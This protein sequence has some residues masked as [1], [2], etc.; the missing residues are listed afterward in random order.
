MS[1]SVK[2]AKTKAQDQ[3]PKKARGFHNFS[4]RKKLSLSH[5]LIAVLALI[6]A[7][8]GLIGIGRVTDKVETM[9]NGPVALLEDSGNLC[10]ASANLQIAILRVVQNDGMSYADYASSAGAD[11][12][13][14]TESLKNL[15]N[16]LTDPD[17]LAVLAAIQSD[18]DACNAS[19]DSL[20]SYLQ[21]GNKVSA[22][23][24]YDTECDSYLEDIAIQAE[25]LNEM[26]VAQG[27]EAYDYAM[28]LSRFLNILGLCIV[29]FVIISSIIFTIRVTTSIT[30]PVNQVTTAAKRFREGDLLA[31]KDITYRSEEELGELAYAVDRTMYTVDTYIKEIIQILEEIG[32]GNLTRSDREITDYVGDFATIKASFTRILGQLNGIMED[33]RT[34]AVQ[35]SDGS[36]QIAAGAQ[37]LAQGAAEQAGSIQE[38]TS[39]LYD[40]V[41]DVNATAETASIAAKFSGL[42]NQEVV[43]CNEQMNQM[44]ATMDDISRHSD[45]ISRI[46]KTIEDIAFQ[47]NILALNAAVEAARAGAAGKGFA[48]VADEVRS[49]ASKSAEASQSTAELIGGTLAAVERGNKIAKE[50]SE[51]LARVVKGTSDIGGDIRRVAEASTQEAEKLNAIVLGINQISEV[52]Q[53]TASTAEESAAASEELSGQASLL[54]NLAAQFRLRS[55]LR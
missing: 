49:L 35:L 6:C 39:N 18:F 51:T 44:V 32:A 33:I 25:I 17:A 24:I 10:S 26:V 7:A 21:K 34:A 40:T 41:K 54:S 27:R 3:K 47:T 36:N 37:T 13:L 1:Q 55:D 14:I 43:N 16:N 53:T 45:E 31:G 12:A 50:T 23:H 11:G 4:V 15:R 20:N 5:G 2:D 46:V 30:N 22:K 38:L 19:L 48:V 9:Y 8:C 28:G 42:A 29:I 52:V